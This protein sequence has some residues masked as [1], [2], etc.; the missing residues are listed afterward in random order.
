MSRPIIFS[1]GIDHP[2]HLEHDRRSDDAAVYRRYITVQSLLGIAGSHDAGVHAA[3]HD[4]ATQHGLND[5][6]HSRMID[7]RQERVSNR[8]DAGNKPRKGAIID[9]VDAVRFIRLIEQHSKTAGLRFTQHRR[10]NGEP[11]QVEFESR[12]INIRHMNTSGVCNVASGTANLIPN[13]IMVSIWVANARSL[14]YEIESSLG[15]V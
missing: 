12:L 3:E 11:E 13:D 14:K 7:K 6:E 2:Y 8:R 5:W 4:L 15:M 10:K 9:I 1:K